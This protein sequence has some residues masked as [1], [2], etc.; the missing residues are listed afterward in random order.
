MGDM[1]L[2]VSEPRRSVP[3]L[4]AQG[5]HFWRFPDS[6]AHESTRISGSMIFLFSLSLSQEAFP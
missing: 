3:A 4:K 1:D 6:T 5:L 2:M